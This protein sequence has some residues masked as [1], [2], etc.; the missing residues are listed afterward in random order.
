MPDDDRFAAME[1]RLRL[2]QGLSVMMVIA[3]VALAFTIV[4]ARPK[5]QLIAQ[6]GELSVGRLTIKDSKGRDRIVMSEDLIVI[7]DENSTERIQIYARHTPHASI[8]LLDD[9][10][11]RV[12]LSTDDDGIA[13]LA[14][15]RRDG[16]TAMAVGVDRK[17][18]GPVIRIYDSDSKRR[19]DIALNEMEEAFETFY[20]EADN[21]LLNVGVNQHKGLVR[22]FDSLGKSLSEQ[23]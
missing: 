23:P 2:Q 16:S 10:G 3:I 14:F 20:D 15:Y 13:L 19:F 5:A 4:F 22:I 6:G 17:A 12:G 8:R 7:S 21:P 11:A 18:G 1:R 9:S